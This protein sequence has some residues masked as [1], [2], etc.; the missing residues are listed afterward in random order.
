M[1][2]KMKKD[3]RVINGII[4]V[5]RGYKSGNRCICGSRCVYRHADGEK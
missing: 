2:D 1:V 4:T 3:R 5:C